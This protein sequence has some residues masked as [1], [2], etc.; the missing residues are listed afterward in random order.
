M[1]KYLLATIILAL[2]AFGL[3]IPVLGKPISKWSTVYVIA[4]TTVLHSVTIG[5]TTYICYRLCTGTGNGYR[6]TRIEGG[7]E[8]KQ[9][10][11]K[12]YDNFYREYGSYIKY[13]NGKIYVF[14]LEQYSTGEINVF[15]ACFDENGVSG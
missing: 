10:M 2:L 13:Y 8:W 1:K 11:G 12:S 6:S 14:G 4:D 7:F 3:H 15:L 5:E 9:A